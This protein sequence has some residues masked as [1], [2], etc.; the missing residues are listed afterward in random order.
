MNEKSLLLEEYKI[1]EG[2]HR[3]DTNRIWIQ[4]QTLIAANF[5]ALTLLAS[6]C[7]SLNPGSRLFS[8]SAIITGVALIGLAVCTAWFF[9]VST[10]SK[11]Q[12]VTETFLIEMEKKLKLPFKSFSKAKEKR[13]GF[14]WP[15][16]GGGKALR[17][18]CI[19]FISVWLVV[20]VLGLSILSSLMIFLY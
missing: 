11:Y 10:D 1:L 16:I 7:S 8:F 6:W 5:V 9:S 13:Q 3:N 2:R 18:L 20:L 4:A 19:F 12:E 15:N 17:A 14:T